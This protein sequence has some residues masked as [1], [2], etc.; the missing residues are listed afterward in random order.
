LVERDAEGRQEAD[1]DQSCR[2]ATLVRRAT[3]AGLSGWFSLRNAAIATPLSTRT[4]GGG[5]GI[6]D[7][8]RYPPPHPMGFRLKAES[9]R[10]FRHFQKS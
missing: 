4:S 5:Y 3:A 10:R 6:H 7:D 2:T 8:R 1:R 9:V